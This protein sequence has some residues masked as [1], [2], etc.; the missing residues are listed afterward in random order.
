MAW[1]KLP[2]GEGK[3]IVLT[4]IRQKTDEPYEDFAARLKEAL[5]RCFLLQL[6]LKCY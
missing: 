4:G 1:R 3:T 2:V 6:E 5:Q